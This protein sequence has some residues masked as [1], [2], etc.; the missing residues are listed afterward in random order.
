[1]T[2]PATY[3]A[4]VSQAF[5]E[6]H[7]EWTRLAGIADW[8]KV[9][10]SADGTAEILLSKGPKPTHPIATAEEMERAIDSFFEPIRAKMQG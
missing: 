1:M 4:E 2:R 8:I 6:Q 3:T 10:P 9:I 7:A 5:V